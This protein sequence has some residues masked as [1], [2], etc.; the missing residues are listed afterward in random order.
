MPDLGDPAA[1]ERGRVE[2]LLRDAPAADV[3]GAAH[4]RAL[5]YIA[6]VRAA[7]AA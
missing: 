6:A 7:D 4:A 2:R 3:R 1:E 5:G